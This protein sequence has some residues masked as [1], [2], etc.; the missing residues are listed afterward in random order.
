MDRPR[1]LEYSGRAKKSQTVFSVALHTFL[2]ISLIYQYQVK[3]ILPEAVV[4]K[5]FYRDMEVFTCC[6]TKTIVD[7]FYL[8]FILF[9]FLE[10]KFV[11][12]F[13]TLF[14]T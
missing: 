1:A 8:I 2:D 9:A 10:N 13:Q 5:H 3:I 6:T 7:S 11:E 12:K 14:I 4:T